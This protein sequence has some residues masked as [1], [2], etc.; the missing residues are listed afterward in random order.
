MSPRPLLLATTNPEKIAEIRRILAGLPIPL[1]TLADHPSI[2]PPEE[3][4][5]TFAENARQKALYYAAATGLD[6]VADDSGIEIAALGGAPGVRSARF[7]GPDASYPERFAAIERMLDERHATDRSARFVAAVA[8]VEAGTVV[9]ETE[10]SVE[11]LISAVPQGGEGFGYD[12]IFYIP[13][14]RCTLAEVPR[15]RKSAVS[16]RGHAFRT[17][18][19]FLEARVSSSGSENRI[20]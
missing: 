14:I 5:A 7:Q 20:E 9:F 6:S 19:A 10:G 18:R 17:L 2:D 16:H 11:G 13:S 12:P 15:E 3:T 8:L 1:Q 4:G